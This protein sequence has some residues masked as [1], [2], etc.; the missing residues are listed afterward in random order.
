MSNR[1]T[2]V[3][4]TLVA[5]LLLAGATFCVFGQGQKLK[6]MVFGDS[7]GTS[8]ASQINTNILAELAGAA[9][10][11][12]PAFVLFAGDLVYAGNLSA[13]QGW[14]NI[15]SPVYQAGIPVYPVMGN[16]DDDSDPT[17]FTNFFGPMLPAN[18]PP[19][20]VH[21]TYAIM[22]SN[23]L[24]LAL[25]NYVNPHRVN[26]NW[27]ISILATNT[28]PH[29]FAMGHDPA[30][31]VNHSDCLDDYPLTRDVFWNALSNAHCRFYFAGHD[32]F[33][34]HMQ[35]SDGD[36]DPA[37]DLHQLIVG[38]AGAPFS[39]DHYPYDGNNSGWTPLRVWHE[40]QYG[41]VTV[42]IDGYRV[43]VTWHHRTGDNT[44]EATADVFTYDARPAISVA[45]SNGQLTLNW[46]GA[47]MLQSAPDLVGAFADLPGA[48]P[49][50][51]IT[52]FDG[53][54]QFYRLRVP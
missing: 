46:S 24:V 43:T 50:Y 17:A 31:K 42:E 41:Y 29:V 39:A 1:A 16:H 37:N 8:L 48:I 13:F 47:A 19:G 23:V 15:M 10:Q 30:F 25:D 28:R 36:G 52:N 32:H 21:R 5:G 49:P 12:N 33:Y 34:D 14:S 6:F 11:E 45:W 20:E 38:T 22:W 7:R 35:L 40:Q 18:G 4:K 44:Y 54:A 2:S 53:G 51:T 3:G 26:T 27:V 9:I